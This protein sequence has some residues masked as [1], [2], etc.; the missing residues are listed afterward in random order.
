MDKELKDQ[1]AHSN[2]KKGLDDYNDGSGLTHHL[3]NDD[4]PGGSNEPES[5]DDDFDGS[6]A[7]GN[8]LKD[9]SEEANPE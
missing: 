8:N 6:I 3:G 2:F 1:T 9:Y 4:Y 5:K 7:L